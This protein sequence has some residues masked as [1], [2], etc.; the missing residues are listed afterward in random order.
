MKTNRLPVF[1]RGLEALNIGMGV[2]VPAFGFGHNAMKIWYE[3]LTVIMCDD[4]NDTFK[5]QSSTISKSGYY[6]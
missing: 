2:K 1:G 6:T 4:K 3:Y 5:P